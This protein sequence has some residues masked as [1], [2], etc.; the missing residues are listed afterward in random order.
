ME[1]SFKVVT[2]RNLV[3]HYLEK[4]IDEKDRELM[5]SRQ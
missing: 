3:T 2:L 1:N 5:N 4:E